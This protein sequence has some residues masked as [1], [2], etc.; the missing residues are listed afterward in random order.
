MKANGGFSACTAVLVGL[1]MAMPAAS[2][3]ETIELR[4]QAALAVARLPA[5][6]TLPA[7]WQANRK[8]E[9][10]IE[11]ESDEP[12]LKNRRPEMISNVLVKNIAFHKIGY[13]VRFQEPMIATFEGGAF[14]VGNGMVAFGVDPFGCGDGYRQRL[15]VSK[16]QGP[17]IETAAGRHYVPGR[18]VMTQTGFDDP[19]EPL[20]KVLERFA[21]QAAAG[22]TKLAVQLF[23]DASAMTGPA[24]V[25]ELS[26]PKLSLNP[27]ED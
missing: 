19:D 6:D 5:G 24:M 3:A 2:S 4:M 7:P 10:V 14:S 16:G 9:V 25:F 27:G 23:A 17:A 22:Q 26:E 21:R 11:F 15:L 1:W 18:F 8:L 20:G 13:R 12:G